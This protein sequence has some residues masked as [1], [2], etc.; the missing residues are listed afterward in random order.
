MLRVCSF[1]CSMRMPPWLCVI[2]LGS[3][4]VPEENRTHSGWPNGTCS[5][6]NSDAGTGGWSMSSSQ[7]WARG[8]GLPGGPGHVDHLLQAGQP[9]DDL[10][11]LGAAVVVPAAVPVAV[12]AEQHLRR[13][14]PEPVADPA[15][16]EVGGAAGPHRADAGRGEHGDDRLRDVRHAGGDPVAGAD[17]HGAQPGGEHADAVRQVGPGQ[18]RQRRGLRLVVQRVLAGLLAPQHV[19]R[20][21][22]PG[23]GEPLGTGHGPAAEDRGR[24]RR[25]LDA[26]VVPDRLPEA[27][28][29]GHRPAPQRGVAVEVEPALAGE[30]PDERG[31]VGAAD[32]VRSRRPQQVTLANLVLRLHIAD[33]A[34]SPGVPA[35]WSPH[36]WARRKC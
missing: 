32:A 22:Q 34:T 36:K 2:A 17:A 10:L 13:Q 1:S 8:D 29:I 30:P 31:D 24:R 4:V 7:A 25:G 21:V 5:N 33:G 3:P 6:S 18:A 15:P 19:L 26:A 23:A 14:L 11:H 20:V 9:R 16:A 27:V 12:H 35:M 28:E